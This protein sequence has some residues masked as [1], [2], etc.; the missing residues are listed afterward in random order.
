M[1]GQEERGRLGSPGYCPAG[2]PY[3]LRNPL[4]ECRSAEIG[5]AGI[6]QVGSAL[7]ARHH[8]LPQ[9][10]TRTSLTFAW[11]TDDT[12]HGEAG[13]SYCE[14]PVSP[15]GELLGKHL[16]VNKTTGDNMLMGRFIIPQKQAPP[17]RRHLR[18]PTSPSH[19]AFRIHTQEAL[20]HP[21]R[22]RLIN[23]SS[24]ALVFL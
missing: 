8:L 3:H 10:S 7:A 13:R 11:R 17:R 5:S 15:W 9:H 22:R 18:S 20:L 2:W 24:S 6:R 4:I 14:A 23:I 1:E 16:G 12:R 19:L 21:Y